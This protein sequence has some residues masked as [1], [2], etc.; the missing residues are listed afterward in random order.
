MKKF[1]HAEKILLG[2]I[3]LV[4]TFIVFAQIVVRTF[5]IG[6]LTWLDELCRVIMVD[7]SFVGACVALWSDHLISLTLLTDKL[8]RK[9]KNVLGL[10]TNVIGAVFC[11]WL[12]IRGWTT[13]IGMVAVNVR[14]V[15]LGIP[16]WLT[17]LPIALSLFG[18]GIRFA[19]LAY[20]NVMRLANS[21]WE[22]ELMDPEG[23]ED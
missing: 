2:A 17:Y 22:I 15:S 19:L 16:Y 6:N 4:L 5:K 23:G 11:V 20:C 8:G 3:F 9:P 10:I 14:T 1:T 12:G 21:D 7:T 18:M 13:M